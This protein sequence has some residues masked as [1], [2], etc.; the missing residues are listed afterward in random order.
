[1]ARLE[2]GDGAGRDESSGAGGR[3]R[4]SMG[5]RSGRSTWGDGRHGL[6]LNGGQVRRL[7]FGDQP[8]TLELS[9]H[10]GGRQKKQIPP[11]LAAL[12]VGM[13]GPRGRGQRI[14]GYREGREGGGGNLRFIREVVK[15]NLRNGAEA[16]PVSSLPGVHSVSRLRPRG[17][18]AW[19]RRGPGRDRG[20]TYR[21][22]PSGAPRPSCRFLLRPIGR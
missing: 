15:V 1:V 6:I 9:S 14:R 10:L 2:A 16:P 8:I 18:N 7:G 22:P 12:G 19:T 11:A 20:A 3:F 5:C 21:A 17:W 13:T 4:P